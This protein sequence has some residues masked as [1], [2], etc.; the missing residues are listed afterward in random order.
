MESLSADST[1]WMVTEVF[2]SQKKKCV[3]LWRQKHRW[4]I[5]TF[6]LFKIWRENILKTNL[7]VNCFLFWRRI[8]NIYFF[9]W[10]TVGT[11]IPRRR[12]HNYTNLLLFTVPPNTMLNF[13][14][15]LHPFISSFYGIKENIIL[16]VS[17]YCLS[18]PW[19]P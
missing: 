6:P 2:L 8:F 4:N 13:L 15:I 1:S 18:E 9:I 7:E 11:W 5:S 3:L 17:N 10:G 19:E 16:N 12:I 14:W